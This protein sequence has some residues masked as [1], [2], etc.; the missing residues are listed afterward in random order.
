MIAT[1]ESL[2]TLQ[3]SPP[4]IAKRQSAQWQG[5]RA[6]TLHL[7]R[8]EPFSCGFR[9][10]YHLLVAIERG[11]RNDGET[12]VE[13]LPKSNLHDLS[14]KLTFIPAGHRYYGWQKPKVLTRATYFY[15]DTSG[16]ILEPGLRFSEVEFRPRMYFF[17]ADLWETTAKLKSLIEKPAS[18]FYAEAL[19][20]VLSHELVRMN[21]SVTFAKPLRG[22]LA[23]WQQRRVTEF[24]EEH[25]TEGI[26]LA[27]LAELV[28]LSPFHFSRAFKHS[29]GVPPHRYHMS[30]RM[31]KAKALLAKPASSVTE[32]GLQ[33][34]FSET[35]AFTTAFRR[36]TA[37][38]PSE[39]RRNLE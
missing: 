32:V 24:V 12:E 25:L 8:N 1:T 18:P 37:C 16:P 13:G 10:P 14:R 4:N 38:T 26:A 22:G 15:L 2:P 39:Y 30:R 9:G 36:F 31:E 34:G 19:A 28:G 6:E 20:L 21:G 35:S 33:L 27:T 17:D 5:I 7:A 23:A 29:F 3:L 11:E